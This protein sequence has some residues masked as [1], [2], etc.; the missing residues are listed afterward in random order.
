MT[1]LG[2]DGGGSRV[3]AL[4]TRNGVEIGRAESGP[5][6]PLSA[7][8]ETAE[9]NIKRAAEKACQDAGGLRVVDAA[10]VGLAGVGRPS[11]AEKMRDA[12]RRIGFPSRTLLTHDARIALAGAAWRDSGVALIAGSGSICYGRSESGVEA[13]CGGWGSLLD[14]AGGG[15]A[16]GLAGFRAAMRAYDGRLDSRVLLESALEFCG[17]DSAEEIVA[18]KGLVEK[19][20]VAEFAPR[21]FSAAETGC[22]EAA[23]IV[24][25]GAGELAAMAA[26]VADRLGFGKS[27]RVWAAGGLAKAYPSYVSAMAEASSL[28]FSPAQ[29]DGAAGAVFLA[30]LLL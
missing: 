28:R 25:E 4:L 6:N 16:V 23:R 1:L 21:V 14:D 24:Q 19:S 10:C 11:A 9:A 17:V 3:R 27:A 8:F 7:G 20:V 15:Y 13:R 12:L 22:P 26:V 5:G 2:I 29:N 18:W 30:K